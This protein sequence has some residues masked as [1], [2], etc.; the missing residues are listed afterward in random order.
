MSA[1]EQ[2]E[3]VEQRSSIK[4]VRNAKGDAQFEIKVVAG[5]TEPE[6][7]AMRQMAVRQYQALAQE[8]AT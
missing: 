8:L 3:P 6:L 5:T 7:D 2:H 4:A 1:P